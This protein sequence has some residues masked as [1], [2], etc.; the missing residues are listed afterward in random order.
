MKSRF[1]L[2]AMAFFWW[3]NVS[4]AVEYFVAQKHP[5]ARDDNTG[6]EARPFKTIQPAVDKAKPGDIIWVKEGIY[7][8]IVKIKSRGEWQAPITLAAWRD[9]PVYLGSQPANLPPREAWKQIE[10][11]KSW[12]TVLPEGTPAEIIVLFNDRP[13]PCE[14]KDTPPAD[15]QILWSTY[16]SADRTLRVN[17]GGANPAERYTLTMAGNHDFLLGL[18]PESSDWTIRGFEFGYA[19]TLLMNHGSCNIIEDCHFHHAYKQAVFAAAGRTGILR[20]CTFDDTMFYGSGVTATII[21]DNIFYDGIRSPDEIPQCR[22]LNAGEPGGGVEF[23]CTG[24]GTVFRYN[25]CDK[26]GYWGDANGTG[27]RIY[28]NAFHDIAFIAIHNEYANDDTLIIGNYFG[29]AWTYI[30]S[31]YSSRM[32]VVDNFMEGSG[33]CVMLHNRDRWQ[34]R[35][36]FMVIRGNAFAGSSLP[37][38]GYGGGYDNAPEGWSNCLVDFNHYRLKVGESSMMLDLNGQVRCKTLDEVRKTMGWELHGEAKPYDPEHNDLTPES[39]G[40]GTVTVRLPVGENRWKSRPMLA[41]PNINC[42]WPASVRY[43]NGLIPAFFWRLADGNYD[44]MTMRPLYGGRAFENNW[45]PEC[46]G[47]EFNGCT[48]NVD[49]DPI[50]GKPDMSP[51]ARLDVSA[52]KANKFLTVNGKAPEKML[53]QGAG[54]WTPVLPAAPEA[55]LDVSFKIRGVTLEP[56]GENGG[57]AVFMRFT[58]LTGQKQSR[59]FFVGR[60]DSGKA[61]NEALGKG[62]YGWTEIRQTVTAPK[63]AGHMALFLGMKPCKGQV[64]FDDVN[65][66]TRPAPQPEAAKKKDALPPR[67]PLQRFRETFFVDLAPFVNRSFADDEPNNG[68]GGWSDQ[69][70]DCDMR[71]I[72]TGLRKFGGVPFNILPDKSLVVL[73]SGRRNSGNLPEKVVIPVDRPADTLFF[74][75][76]EAWGGGEKDFWYVIHYADGKDVTL[77]VNRKNGPGWAEPPR[78]DFP[79]EEGTQTDVAETVPTPQFKQGSIYR[80]EW[81]SPD[82]RRGVNI[83]SIEFANDPGCVPI[84]AGITGVIE[85]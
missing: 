47:D 35:D 26:S 30:A 41:D 80:M 6:T 55:T 61:N 44:D 27:T 31:S 15:D 50:P 78:S 5:D 63:E 16:S 79:A 77:V 38:S 34:M 10:G 62:S 45:W 84:L 40:A 29:S 18:Y 75:H 42:R 53:P 58:S 4:Y 76:A 22:I 20:R 21:E 64:H 17:A 82:D 36:S 13:Q 24:F 83:H 51:H 25:F 32:S 66:K 43:V 39:L 81:N 54:W 2:A 14:L 68:I 8:D 28:G 67:L 9:D 85:W 65:I 1:L 73:K 46:V 37:L 12:Q 11:T 72:K 57:P 52:G 60:D 71:E 33:N 59:V 19:H 70:P 7:G 3:L 49:T 69:G 56:A 23:K 74:L 48:W